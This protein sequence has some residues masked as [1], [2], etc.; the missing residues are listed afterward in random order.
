MIQVG[1]FFTKINLQAICTSRSYSHQHCYFPYKIDTGY[2]GGIQTQIF[3]SWGDAMTNPAVVSYNASAVDYSGL[4]RFEAKIF[5]STLKKR[6]RLLQR[7]RCG[8][9]FRS[10][11]G[12]G[13]QN[14]F[15]LNLHTH[16]MSGP[17]R[18]LRQ[19]VVHP[20]SHVLHLGGLTLQPLQLVAPNDV[21]ESI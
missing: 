12:A 3:S 14:Y 21:L 13:I 16:L 11:L 17:F 19:D 9:K 10:R 4:V 8:C 15:F 20:D 5:S 1:T 6:S 7:W 2:L 18:L